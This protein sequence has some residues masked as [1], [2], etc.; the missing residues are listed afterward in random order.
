MISVFRLIRIISLPSFSHHIVCQ[1]CRYYS[2][3][4]HWWGVIPKFVVDD[5]TVLVVY[6]NSKDSW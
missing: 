5:R 1:T 4:R 2:S 6:V 3:W